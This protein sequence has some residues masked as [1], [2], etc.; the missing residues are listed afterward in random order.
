MRVWDCGGKTS[1]TFSM[2]CSLQYISVTSRSLRHE[3]RSYRTCK[4]KVFVTLTQK[5]KKKV[6]LTLTLTLTLTVTLSP[7]HSATRDC[8]RLWCTAL[9]LTHQLTLQYN[10]TRRKGC[11]AHDVNMTYSKERYMKNNP[12]KRWRNASCDKILQCDCT[13][14]YSAA[15]HSLYM[16]FTRPSPF[17]SGSGSGLR[18]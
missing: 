1:G 2:Y 8:W 16:L 7:N 17:S 3:R 11:K 13:A 9:P 6:T 10:I 5:K 4:T 18:D 15:G 14:L 12:L